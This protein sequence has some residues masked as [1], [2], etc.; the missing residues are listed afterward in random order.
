MARGGIN[1]ALVQKA[2]QALLARGENPSID[3]VRVE[4]GNTGSKTTIHRYLRELDAAEPIPAGNRQQLSEELGNLVAGLA[5]RLRE[6]AEST[7]RNEQAAF[8]REWEGLMQRLEQ[9]RARSTQLEERVAH[10]EQALSTEQS[11]HWQLQERSQQLMVELARLQQ[12]Q[13]DQQTRLDERASQIAS[14]E[15]KHQHARE[16]LEH[17]RNSVKEQREQEQRRHAGQIQQL[18]V[19][20][21]QGQQELIARQGETLQLNRDN[22]RLLGELR[23]TQ[24]ERATLQDQLER[25]DRERSELQMQL[26]R[27]ETLNASLQEQLKR[28][29]DQ[30]NAL[31]AELV[32]A[33]TDESAKAL[34]HLQAEQLLQLALARAEAELQVLRQ[35]ACR[36]PE[37]PAADASPDSG[38]GMD[39]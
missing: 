1:K 27:L 31:R 36:T 12:L 17:Y 16:T 22:E 19:E 14:L 20:L 32:Q 33:R 2:R 23:G 7:L 34:Q 37:T 6:E 29:D 3:A 28:L 9:A 5:E 4:L 39:T 18:Q 21:R 8:A 26:T 11:D 24:R 38:A 10:L 15:E 30:L 35:S 25:R 13:H